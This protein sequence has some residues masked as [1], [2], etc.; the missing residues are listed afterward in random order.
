MKKKHLNILESTEKNIA[1]RW[2]YTIPIAKYYCMQNTKREARFS[3]FGKVFRKEKKYK[4]RNTEEYQAGIELINNSSNGD[5]LCLK[6]LQETLDTLKLNNLKLELGSAKIFTRICEL[7]KDDRN[8]VEILS[9][10][11]IS[12]MKK[13]ISGKKIDK[14]LSEFLLKLPR[15][16]GDISMINSIISEV[17]DKELLEALKELK[18]IYEKLNNKDSIIFDL[19]MCPSME[20]YTGIMFKVY[21][22][23]APEALVC[24]GRYDSLYDKF[25]TKAKAIGMSY[26]FSNILKALESEVKIK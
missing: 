8:I 16:C 25:Q 10:K 19:S 21:S 7:T 15:L 1:L 4:G 22:L 9:K 24:G 5:E 14:N 23:N 2:D 12:E 26:Y 6:I 17:S 20:Y 13:F 3:Y 18:N 11:N